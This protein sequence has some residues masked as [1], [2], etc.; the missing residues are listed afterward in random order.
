MDKP[1]VVDEQL[2]AARLLGRNKSPGHDGVPL[3]FF[4]EFWGELEHLLLV[5][6]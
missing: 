1:L 5:E 2:A 3:E 6:I 4:L